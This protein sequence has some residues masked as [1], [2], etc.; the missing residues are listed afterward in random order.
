M[1]RID[2]ET[3]IAFADGEL[4]DIERAR[5]ERALQGDP[6]LRQR[7]EAHRRVRDRLAGHYEPVAEEPVPDRFRQLLDPRVVPLSHARR[8][9]LVPSW[10]AASA[11]AATLVIGIVL[12]QAVPFGGSGPIAA[13]NGTLL[14][15][16]GLAEALET[17]LAS[18]QPPGAPVRIGIT[19]PGPDGRICRTFDGAIVSGLACRDLGRWR[20]LVAAP[21]GGGAA[22]EYRQAGSPAPV[23]ETAQRLMT[24][25]PLD[26]EQERSAR[27][28]GWD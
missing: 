3:L 5:V 16:G 2:E 10:Q 1:T 24:G 25:D 28:S 14:A 8:R 27:D 15:G 13:E 18:T 22:G 12:G 23:M 6:A 20:L 7:L 21:G 19:F 17:Q 4:S 26:A 9:R 11:L